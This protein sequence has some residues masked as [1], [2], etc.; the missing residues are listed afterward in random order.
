MHLIDE[1]VGDIDVDKAGS[2]QMQHPWRWAFAAS[3]LA[4]L[5]LALVASPPQAMTT[6]WDKSNHLLAFGVMTWLG[7]KAFAQRVW[8]VLLGLL[9]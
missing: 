4:V 3:V 9:A 8:A 7:C 1:D 5:V 2:F 6:G